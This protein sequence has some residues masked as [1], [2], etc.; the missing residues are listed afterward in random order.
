[1]IK[2]RFDI[3]T[4]DFDYYFANQLPL[5]SADGKETLPRDVVFKLFKGGGEPNAKNT[6]KLNFIARLWILWKCLRKRFWIVVEDENGLNPQ[7]FYELSQAKTRNANMI[8][9]AKGVIA[10]SHFVLANKELG[11]AL[12][13]LNRICVSPAYNYLVKSKNPIPNKVKEWKDQMRYIVKVIRRYE[14]MKKAWVAETGLS[15]PE[16]YVLLGFY[17][18]D[19]MNGAV[20][21]N[22]TFKRAY[23]SS[24]NR[25]KS[26]FGTLQQRGYITKRGES[27]GA[28]MAITSLGT[29][30]VNSI[31]TRYAL[32]C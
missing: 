21:Y 17:D 3:S 1:M 12:D 18:V 25:I 32:N 11:D 5:I 13:Q 14:G 20:L 2:T 9:T 10:E 26:A 8:E 27:K 30:A 29:D 7:Q 16:F 24:P 28:K 19:E 15:I 23:Q 4:E 31:L 6:S 22:D